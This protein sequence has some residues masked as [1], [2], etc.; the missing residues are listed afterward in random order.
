MAR[1]NYQ[2][3]KRQRDLAR[4]RKQEEKRLKKTQKDPLTGENVAVDGTAPEDAAAETDPV[5][6]EQAQAE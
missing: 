2:R 4:Q 6:P 3:D 1:V 5:A